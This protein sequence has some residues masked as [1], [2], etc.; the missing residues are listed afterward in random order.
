MGNH[1]LQILFLVHRVP[2]PPNRGDRIRSFHMLDYMSG[3]ADVHLAFPTPQPP[4]E[5]TMR[6]LRKRC[7]RVA[8]EPLGWGARWLRAARSLAMGRTATEGLFQCPALHRVVRRWSEEIRF[9]AVVVFCSSMAQYLD[10]RGLD[11]V[12]AVIDLVDVDSQKWFDYAAQSRGPKR[13]LFSLEGRRL[14]RLEATLAE[15]ARAVTVVSDAEAGLYRRFSPKAAV[16][17]IGNGVDLDYFRAD[18]AAE[19]CESPRCV[20]VGALDYRANVEGARWFCREVWPEI[21]RRVPGAVFTLVGSNPTAAARRLAELPGVELAADVPDVRPYLDDAAMVVVPLRVARGIQNK[22]L[23]ALARGKA[24]V[25]SP[26]SLDGLELDRA[27]HV[28]QAATPEE[29][30]AAVTQ[31]LDDPLARDRLGREGRKHVQQHYCW[32]TRLKPFGALLGLPESVETVA[33]PC[34][35]RSN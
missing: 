28:R 29:W 9:D 19:A 24:V 3:R 22:V 26:P 16:H 23:E 14:R 17:A 21:H 5:E 1:R 8:A 27:V 30:I 12:P 34:Q 20:F 35:A 7:R 4:D 31:L 10:A 13:W 2:Y 32:E 33:N 25:A 15:R 6:A 18:P 11:G